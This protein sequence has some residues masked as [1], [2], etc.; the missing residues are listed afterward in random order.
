[1][2]LILRS[3]SRAVG[4]L[5][6]LSAPLA[7]LSCGARSGSLD[8]RPVGASPGAPAD[9]APWPMLGQGREHQSRSPFA[10]KDTPHRSW[11]VALDGA[12]R[13]VRPVSAS[14]ARIDA[15]SEN[16]LPLPAWVL[17]CGTPRLASAAGTVNV[18]R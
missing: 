3:G 4:A 2:N 13:P 10:T 11:Q 8:D 18:T 7:L 16:G 14:A 6:L 9:E 1:M 15:W 12:L 5:S 17:F